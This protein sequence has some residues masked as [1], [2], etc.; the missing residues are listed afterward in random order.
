[1][2][3]IAAGGLHSMAIKEDGSVVAWGD[4][5]WGQTNVPADLGS[6]TAIS[7]GGSHS[8]AIKEDG[9]VVAWGNNAEGQTNVPASL[10]HVMAISG[11]VF[12]S[13][14]IR[15]LVAPAAP[16]ITAPGE[17]SDNDGSFALSGSAEA[18]STVEL[19]EGTASKGTDTADASGDWSKELTGVSDG[20]HTYTAK[21]TDGVGNVSDPSEGRTVVVDATAPDAPIIT[22][23]VEGSFDDDGFF[24]V[25][26]T[27]QSGAKVELFEGTTSKGTDTAGSDRKWGIALSRVGEGSHT[28]TAKATDGVGN[29]SDPSEGR[30]VVV[31]ATAPD[32]PVIKSPAEGARVVGS[33]AVKG[34]A[35]ANGTVE[36]FE[37]AASV[38][39]DT[40]D[41]SGDWSIALSGVSDG[42]H[43]Y[44][45]KAT[46]AA[47]N[48]SAES[49]VRTLIV[50]SAAP[51]VSSVVPQE[52]DTGRAPA[53][54]VRAFFSE[55]MRASSISPHTVKLFK[56]GAPTTPLGAVVSYAPATKQALL[57]PDANLVL[58]TRYRAVVT[59]GAKDEAGNRL[60]QDQDPSNGNQP[61]AWF[62]TV[63]NN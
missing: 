54:N 31:D 19:F 52:N 15:D 11:G 56:V 13:L 47:G 36:L 53:T 22:R 3:A 46:D 8:M 5:D 44:K 1:V 55:A 30:T 4:N 16:L 37:G 63:R 7:A 62:F 14:A 24:F 32:A 9:T 45:A 40:A 58:G 28:Y 57:N 20:S 10:H 25:S 48:A 29:V 26:G 2:K 50:D 43:A 61:K 41:S 18:G 35:E 51:Q 17:G 38:G 60:D 6:V 33:F 49:E 34:T 39:T 21:A 27:A 59:T 12:H 23:P 42:S